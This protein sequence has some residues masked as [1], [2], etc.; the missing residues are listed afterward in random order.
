MIFEDYITGERIQLLCDIFVGQDYD[1][2]YNPLIKKQ[3]QTKQLN[4]NQINQSFSNPKIIFLYTHYL[5]NLINIIE[6]FQNPFILI[7]HNSDFELNESY[8]SIINH[9]KIIHIFSQNSILSHLKVTNLPIGIANSMW[10]HGDL[11]FLHLINMQNKN[12]KN[13]FIYLQFSLSTYEKRKNILNKLIEKNIEVQPNLEYLQYLDLLSTFK[14]CICARGNGIDTHRFWE[15][16]Y[17]N[18]IPICEKSIFTENLKKEY[19]DIILLDSFDDL[20]IDLL[21]KDYK[22]PDFKKPSLTNIKNQINQFVVS[23]I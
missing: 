18:V 12:I 23:V 6:Y 21:E 22:Y 16:I 2:N 7:L 13:N 11:Y 8:L 9:P 14:Y 10:K 3:E 20:N 4:I 15:C 1:F 5:P 17:L 19:K